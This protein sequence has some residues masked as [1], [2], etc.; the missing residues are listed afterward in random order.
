MKTKLVA[1]GTVILLAAQSVLAVPISSL[2]DLSLLTPFAV[3]GH[4]LNLQNVTVTGNVGVSQN[5]TFKLD[6]PS[7]V[8]GNASLGTGV[9][10]SGGG[11]PGNIS[12]STLLN[13]NFAAAQAQLDTASSILAG[14]T[15]NLTL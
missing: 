8:V 5:G 6:A 11:W 12:G 15:P 2:P 14:L 10:A 13:Q 7:H 4:N 3:F 9:T 1:V